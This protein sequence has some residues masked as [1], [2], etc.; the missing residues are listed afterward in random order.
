MKSISNEYVSAK[1]FLSAPLGIVTIVTLVRMATRPVTTQLASPVP[2]WV[3][4][5]NLACVTLGSEVIFAT[6][7]WFAE[8]SADD[9]DGY[10]DGNNNDDANDDGAGREPPEPECRGVEGG[11]HRAGQVDGRLGDPQEACG[12]P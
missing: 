10:D 6:D 5:N 7:D 4:L 9:N 12:W 2:E 3:E 11:V 8:V 1:V